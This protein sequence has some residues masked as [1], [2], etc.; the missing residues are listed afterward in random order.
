MP[1]LPYIV[2]Q[3]KYDLRIAL[4]E[5]KVKVAAAIGADQ[6]AGKHIGVLR[7]WCGV[8]GFCPASAAPAH[9]LSTLDDRLM[10][11]LKHH[12]IFTVIADPLLIL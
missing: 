9:T 12:P 3:L 6:Q 7:C 4:I 2:G 5:V 8:C 1:R 10:D 11:I